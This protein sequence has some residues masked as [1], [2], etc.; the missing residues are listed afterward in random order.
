MNSIEN[1]ID[2]TNLDKI[3]SFIMLQSEKYLYE[4]DKPS[5]NKEI[6]DIVKKVG[7]IYDI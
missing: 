6:D 3:S 1:Q 7:K 5:I 2:T 4:E